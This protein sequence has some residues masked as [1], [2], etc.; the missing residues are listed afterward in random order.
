MAYQLV[1]SAEAEDDFRNMVLYI[2]ETWSV[3]SS[4]KFIART[5]RRLEKLTSMPTLARPTSQ[6]LIY[7]Y[8]LD[9]KNVLFFSLEEN[10]LILLSIYPYKRDITRS[11]YY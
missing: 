4:E 10:Y 2:K 1:W 7:M 8:K 6:Q 9:R 3:Q 11:K 5:Y